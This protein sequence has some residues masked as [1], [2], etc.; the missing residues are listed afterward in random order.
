MNHIAGI[1]FGPPFRT[2]SFTDGEFVYNTVV[3]VGY[4]RSRTQRD[5]TE[6]RSRTKR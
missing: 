6:V 2:K 4:P 1:C 3:V 5:T